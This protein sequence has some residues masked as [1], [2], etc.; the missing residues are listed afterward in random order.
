MIV[1][2]P[3]NQTLLEGEKVEFPCEAKA[4]PGNVTVM[5]KREGV[6]IDKLSWLD[7]RSFI[8]R[9]GAL[10]INPTSSEDGGFFTCE[11]S[12]GIGTPQKATAHLNVECKLFI[13]A[14]ALI[15][16]SL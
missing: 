10:V 13:K 14:Q 8:R 16:E 2:P 4:L 5:W 9:D 7:S 11:V 12:N 3:Q 6:A 15:L 1:T